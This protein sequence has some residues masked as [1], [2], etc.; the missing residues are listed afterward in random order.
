MLY[1]WL[2]VSGMGPVL[3][4]IHPKVTMNKPYYIAITAIDSLTI[5]TY[6]GTATNWDRCPLQDFRYIK[7]MIHISSF[8]QYKNTPSR[9]HFYLSAHR[10]F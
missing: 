7:R 6:Q 3:A 10:A 8:L 5:Y 4:V 2:E 9:Y 1:F